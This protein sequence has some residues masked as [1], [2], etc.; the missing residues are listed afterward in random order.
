MGQQQIPLGLCAGRELFVWAK[1]GQEMDLGTGTLKLSIRDTDL[2]CHET[3]L[4][5]CE[6]SQQI[7]R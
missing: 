1:L 6:Q 3:P 2:F 5:E 4:W 7:F